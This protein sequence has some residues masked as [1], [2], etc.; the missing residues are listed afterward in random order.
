MV[1]KSLTIARVWLSQESEGLGRALQ[2]SR[3]R[4][5]RV[6]IVEPQRDTCPALVHFVTLSAIRG[7]GCWGFLLDQL[8]QPDPARH[9]S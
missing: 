1:H 2:V 6:T 7:S 5:D 8:G 9:G 4:C 3:L